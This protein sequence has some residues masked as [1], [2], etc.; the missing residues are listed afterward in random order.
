MGWRSAPIVIGGTQGSGTRGVEALFI[1]LGI[2]LHPSTESQLF[3]ECY[4][5]DPLDNMCMKPLGGGEAV[6]RGRSG[7]GYLEWLQDEECHPVEWHTPG[8]NLTERGHAYVASVP[9]SNRKPLR[10]GWKLPETMLQLAKL[11]VY[12]PGM[13][14]VHVLR[15]PLDMAASYMEHLPAQSSEF[16]MLHGGDDNAVKL[17]ADRCTR[18][19][20]EI[21]G[22]R[23]LE[24]CAI[25][26]GVLCYYVG[27]WSLLPKTAH[28]RAGKD[29]IIGMVLSPCDALGRNQPCCAFV[30]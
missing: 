27:L 4:N 7:F 21:P 30:G 8:L 6:W 10:W 19:V 26:K 11:Y 22:G 3:K 5:G 15:N 9:R 28:V 20:N 24:Q 13:V 25:S 14:F 29:S 2:Y 16:K 17:M 23:K 18:I 12:F 1:K